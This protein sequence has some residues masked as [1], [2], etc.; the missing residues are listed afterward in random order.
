MLRNQLAPD[1]PSAR[2]LDSAFPAG[3]VGRQHYYGACSWTDGTLV[4]VGTFYPGN[5]R[6]A[7]DRLVHCQPVSDRRSGRDLLCAAVGT[8]RASLGREN[9]ARLLFNIKVFGLFTHHPVAVERLPAAVKELLPDAMAEKSRVYL[10][11]IPEEAEKLIW[12][13]Q[14]QALAPL[15]A[16][17]KLGCMLFQFPHWFTP[18][19]AHIRYLEQLRDRT[20][21][22]IAVEFRGGGWM[23]DNYRAGTLALLEKLGLAY[24]VVDEPQ[25]FR[26][27]T[28]PV[29]AATSPLAILRFH[30]HNAETYEK[31]NISAA[32]R[33]RY[34]YTEDELKGWVNPIR[35]LADS[36]D[37]AC[38]T[39]VPPPFERLFFAVPSGVTARR[40]SSVPSRSCP[41]RTP[42]G[43]WPPPFRWHWR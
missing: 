37:R 27:S 8:Q 34:L 39:G 43:A 23:T 30:G 24:V 12:E 36:T 31:P 33:F 21:W 5:A 35:R 10:R 19:R 2:R 9:R 32:E 40:G 38:G 22:P 14:A 26:S 13:M 3:Q 25:G 28:P 42:R 18:G 41:P 29:V 16:A 4:N 11:D 17:G 7:A 20:E 15:A 1:E 6:T